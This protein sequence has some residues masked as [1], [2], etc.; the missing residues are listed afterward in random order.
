[1][2]SKR[3]LVTLRRVASI[4]RTVIQRFALILE[5]QELPD[6]LGWQNAK[7]I[8]ELASAPPGTFRK[9]KNRS[10]GKRAMSQSEATRIVAEAKRRIELAD[11]PD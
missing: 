1:V 3:E 9:V 7:R 5:V 2:V 8:V 11:A 10:G 6:G 4:A